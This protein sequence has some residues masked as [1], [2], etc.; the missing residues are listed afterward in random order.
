DAIT[1]KEMR[2][3]CFFAQMTL[4]IQKKLD[5]DTLALMYPEMDTIQVKVTV[6][7]NATLRF[8][9]Q[10]PANANYNMAQ[11]DS[12]IKNR[13]VNF[14]PVVP[15]QKEGV[16]VTTQFMLPVVLNVQK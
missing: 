15:A 4:L 6:F 2:K 16:P 7:S 5:I 3:D 14:P 13:L 12:L 9:P 11:I 10:L 8:E 1:D